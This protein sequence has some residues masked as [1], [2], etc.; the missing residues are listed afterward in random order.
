MTDIILVG[1]FYIFICDYS[2]FRQKDDASET[3]CIAWESNKTR[4][5]LW[6]CLIRL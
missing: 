6:D 1:L 2:C 4:R 5:A 3:L